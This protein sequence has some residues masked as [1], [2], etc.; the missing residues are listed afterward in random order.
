MDDKT[1]DF[2][3]VQKPDDVPTASSNGHS[4]KPFITT[5]PS[6]DDAAANPNP[7]PPLD[8]VV[9]LEKRIEKLEGSTKLLTL[10]QLVILCLVGGL[11][12]YIYKGGKVSA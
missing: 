9:R 5:E 2:S 11:T 3:T 4:A 6:Q 12:F 1:E 7:G 8:E 10:N